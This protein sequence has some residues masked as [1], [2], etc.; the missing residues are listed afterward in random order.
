MELLFLPR[1]AYAELFYR[2]TVA[3]AHGGRSIP[4]AC[5]RRASAVPAAS[6]RADPNCARPKPELQLECA[7]GLGSKAVFR[8][9]PGRD[10]VPILI[11]KLF[12]GV[13]NGVDLTLPYLLEK[14]TR[15]RHP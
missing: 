7:A 3:V 10:A 6:S 4:S 11:R 12:A 2:T 13:V 9:V 14:R 5:V 8:S 15:E 1:P